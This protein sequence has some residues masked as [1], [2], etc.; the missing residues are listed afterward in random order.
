MPRS[1][2]EILDHAEQLADHFEE[3]PPD[4]A[5]MVRRHDSSCAA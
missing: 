1:L 3:N 4:P 2:Q 5:D